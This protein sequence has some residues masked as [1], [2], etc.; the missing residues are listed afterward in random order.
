MQ[1]RKNLIERVGNQNKSISS[2]VFNTTSE[3]V[4][5]IDPN[6]KT[7]E[8][9]DFVCGLLGVAKEE[10]IGETPAEIA[11]K[12][13]MQ[14]LEQFSYQNY[15]ENNTRFE[16]VL[17]QPF[18]P[19][20]CKILFQIVKLDKDKLNFAFALITCERTAQT[21]VVK[22][23][24]IEEQYNNLIDDIQ[25]GVLIVHDSIILFSN[26]SMSQITGYANHEL[27]GSHIGILLSS[28]E[29]KAVTEVFESRK[30]QKK[31]LNN[32]QLPILQK[33][34]NQLFLNLMASMTS[35]KGKSATIITAKDITEE[36]LLGQEKDISLKRLKF[37]FAYIDNLLE[38]MPIGFWIIDFK[39]L[40]ELSK[41]IP[42]DRFHEEIGFRAVIQ[43]VNKSLTEIL[44]YSKESF[45][46]KS[47]FDPAFIDEENA[48]VFLKE[49]K[50]RMQ[51]KRGSYELRLKHKDGHLVPVAIESIPT[52]IDPVT[53]KARQSIGLIVDQTERKLW[54]NELFKLNQSLEELSFKDSLTNLANRRYFD[55]FTQKEWERARREKWELSLIFIDIDYFKAY[56]D[57]YG[58]QA[59]DD[60]L[61]RVAR[62]LKKMSHRS[63]D[64]VARYGGE[65]FAVVLPNTTGEGAFKLA[66]DLRKAI[67]QEEIIHEFSKNSSFLT[68]SLGVATLIP[69]KNTYPHELLLLADQALYKSKNEGRN[70]VNLSSAALR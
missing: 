8:V 5:V 63:S 60:C 38:V 12:L 27:V 44:G 36:I 11:N 42:F 20:R 28:K 53:N 25:D 46:G 39:P 70:K 37:D 14:G 55:E 4:W 54:E 68:I 65:E 22:E 69:C 21:T 50:E 6:E 43:R 23:A 59:G 34:G 7:V 33:N 18:P 26:S 16:I 1:G 24:N 51:G 19:S 57:G 2:W 49:V 30:T 3:G 67:E 35:Y 56:N 41:K 10:M 58:H 62:I 13:K 61:K 47:I 17:T 52:I 15:S 32:Y 9:D 64:L 66:E 45:I 48:E 31:W 29:V 40:E